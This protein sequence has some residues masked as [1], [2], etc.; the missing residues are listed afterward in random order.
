MPNPF[1]KSVLVVEDDEGV[2]L[3]ERRALER[4]GFEVTLAVNLGG[5]LAAVQAGNFALIV[6][7][8]RL[9]SGTGLEL[10]DRLA[11]LGR[12]IPVILVTG[13]SDE[14]TVI[15]ALRAGAR[16]FVPKSSEYLQYLPDAVERVLKA[17][18]TERELAESES[19]FQLFMENSPAAAFIKDNQG[20]YVYANRVTREIIGASSWHGKM[21]HQIWPKDGADTIREHDN[22]ILE[23]GQSAEVFESLVVPSGE[24]RHYRSF[25]F[26]MRDSSGRQFVGGMAVD[27]TQ[28]RMVEDELRQRDEQLRQSQKMEAIGTLAGGIAH[29]FNNLLQAVL[30]YTRFAMSSID[31]SHDAQSDLRVVVTAAERAASLTQQLLTFSRREQ[32]E[33]SPL[34]VNLA[35]HELIGMLR[36]LIGESI[37]IEITLDNSVGP[38]LA[39]S[40]QIQQLLMNLCLNARDAMSDGGTITIST[41]ALAGDAT[42]PVPRALNPMHTLPKRGNYLVL[43]VADTGCGMTDATRQKLFEPFFT[44]KPV[45]KGTGLG[46]AMVYGAVQQHGGEICVDSELGKGA[47]FTVYL[48]MLEADVAETHQEPPV[49]MQMGSQTILIAED[50][51]LVLNLAKR[52]LEGAGYRVI[53]ATNGEEAVRAFCEHQGQVSLVVLDAAMPQRTGW[54]ALRDIRAADPCVPAIIATGYDRQ[55][56]HKD[57]EGPPPLHLP[58]PFDLSQLLVLVQSTLLENIQC[59]LL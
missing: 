53:V 8:Y 15:D 45:G 28:Q 25:K 59:S 40:A 54:E 57:V 27:V 44:T 18:R 13:F 51:P 9:E 21:D 42:H 41:Q 32:G 48:P 56:D 50:E 29:E 19:R 58:K 17:V 20:R 7:D 39:D 38:I 1:S 47:M 26:P 11:A 22:L 12:E 3:L 14:K 35:I 52:T 33:F 34:D 43:T 49:E 6:S 30:G 16:D 46:L 23:S 10:L 4:R 5:A 31:S 55:S 37:R 36:P 24:L 2:A